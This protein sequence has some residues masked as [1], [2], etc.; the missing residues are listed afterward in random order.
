MVTA[1][2]GGSNLFQESYRDLDDK[3]VGKWISKEEDG[4]PHLNPLRNSY[5]VWCKMALMCQADHHGPAQSVKHKKNQAVSRNV[6]RNRGAW[7]GM[8]A[9]AAAAKRTA[10]TRAMED[11]PKL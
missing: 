4:R 11:P 9:A 5:E 8:G 7:Q 10:E 6:E 3:R 2:M 1:A